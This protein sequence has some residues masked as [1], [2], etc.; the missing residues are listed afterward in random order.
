MYV[1]SRVDDVASAWISIEM[2]KIGRT[3]QESE[4]MRTQSWSQQECRVSHSFRA[5]YLIATSCL[6][7]VEFE[8]FRSE[9]G[10]Q[11]AE[12]STSAWVT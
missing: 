8:S 3:T 6:I 10:G 9:V 7:W 11:N 12:K 4:D 5:S 2:K 1:S